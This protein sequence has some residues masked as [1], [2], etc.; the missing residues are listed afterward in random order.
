MS[1][2]RKIDTFAVTREAERAGPSFCT[3]AFRRHGIGYLDVVLAALSRE[4]PAALVRRSPDSS[5]VIVDRA[6]QAELCRLAGYGSSRATTLGFASVWYLHF[7]AEHDTFSSSDVKLLT[8]Q[9]KWEHVLRGVEESWVPA[10]WPDWRDGF[11][12]LRK[13]LRRPGRFP[14]MDDLGAW[15][16]R[17]EEKAALESLWHVINEAPVAT[18]LAWYRTASPLYRAHGGAIH[19]EPLS[20]IDDPED[21]ASVTRSMARWLRDRPA[22][23]WIVNTWGTPT[24]T[25]FGWHYLAWKRPVMKQARFV[26]C[27]TASSANVP[28]QRFRPLT[29][30]LAPADP[31]GT[32]ERPSATPAWASPAREET[33]RRFSKCLGHRDNFSM[34]VM[35]PR[36]IG[37]TRT[38]R[39]AAQELFGK[40]RVV[41]LNCASFPDPVHARSEL[42]GH[43]AGA[44]TGATEDR[45]GALELAD[46]GVLFLDEVHLLDKDTRGL[47]LTALQTDEDGV[48]EFRPLGSSKAKR[49]RLQPI[50]GTN[51][52][53]SELSQEFSSDFLDR[54]S[55][56]VFVLPAIGAG[57]R[58]GV[59]SEVWAEMKFAGNATDP[60]EEPA[61]LS[62][63]DQQDLSGN[64]RDLQRVAIL[65]ADWQRDE[66][67]KPRNLVA[68]LTREFRRPVVGSPT[69]RRARNVLAEQA[70]AL[71]TPPKDFERLCRQEYAEVWAAEH[72]GA[73]NAAAGAI[74]EKFRVTFNDATFG[75][76][77][78]GK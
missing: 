54:I 41:V 10:A 16:R 51:K 64:F 12:A 24:A 36:G 29:I 52:T 57:E 50:F 61:F 8:G 59:W 49:T 74:R 6:E 17:Y 43:R 20:E 37:K 66:T 42:F 28:S 7:D 27:R 55:Q 70:I 67:L 48:L 3:A 76:W 63:L 2:R 47:L 33:I 22:T 77:R 69:G 25:Q 26:R 72:G 38:V 56:R 5:A 78:G 58:R 32:L 73:Q 39:A 53:W 65:V 4:G 23:D 14:D 71:K 60:A 44:F 21:V 46:D 13:L 34:L 75:R 40:D 30:D 31:I 62:W 68:W 18:Q 45:P 15:A 9:E 35:G 11:D 19:L 1:E